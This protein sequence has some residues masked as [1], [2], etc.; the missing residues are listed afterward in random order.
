MNG[1]LLGQKQKPFIFMSQPCYGHVDPDSLA[2]FWAAPC[3]PNIPR[4]A[5]KINSSLLARGFNELWTMALN[6]QDEGQPITHFV[7]LHADIVPEPMWA[8]KLLNELTTHRAD[9]VSAVVPIKTQEGL[10]ST[11]IDGESEPWKVEKRLSMHEVMGL[12]TT[13]TAADCGFPGRRLLVNTGCWIA[14]FTKAWRRDVHFEISDR[15]V[16]KPTGKYVAETVPEDWAFSRTLARL[17][18]KVMATRAVR[19]T[20]GGKIDYPNSEAWGTVTREEGATM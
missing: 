3:G 18:C 20:H 19:L 15:I 5:G 7:M 8:E 12:P 13:F 4:V 17:G 6:M 11:A 9:V 10:T 16:R 14:D 1:L 2:A